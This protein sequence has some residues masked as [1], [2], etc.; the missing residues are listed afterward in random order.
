LAIGLAAA[1]LLAFSNV[2]LAQESTTTTTTHTEH[3]APGLEIGVPGVAGVQIGGE[4]QDCVTRRTTHTDE[5]T[6]DS[7]TST[8]TRCD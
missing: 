8:R 3:S 4:R 5:E 1:S 6:G 2:A 7:H